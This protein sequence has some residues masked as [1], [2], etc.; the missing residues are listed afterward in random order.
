MSN[1]YQD[2]SNTK[3]K[4]VLLRDK[5]LRR[6]IEPEAE[7]RYHPIT[8]SLSRLRGDCNHSTLLNTLYDSVGCIES[9]LPISDLTTSCLDPAQ[10]DDILRGLCRLLVYGSETSVQTDVDEESNA[11]EDDLN[12]VNIAQSSD[13][14]T[15][16]EVNVL[17]SFFNWRKNIQLQLPLYPSSVECSTLDLARQI[18][19]GHDHHHTLWLSDLIIPLYKRW[20][21]EERFRLLQLQQPDPQ[22]QLDFDEKMLAAPNTTVANK[23]H[24]DLKG[25]SWMREFLGT[26]SRCLLEQIVQRSIGASDIIQGRSGTDDLVEMFGLLSMEAHSY[27]TLC[28][29]ATALLGYQWVELAQDVKRCFDGTARWTTTSIGVMSSASDTADIEAMGSIDSIGSLW[30]RA[31]VQGFAQHHALQL[32]R[33]WV[34]YFA[35]Y[36]YTLRG[37]DADQEGEAEANQLPTSLIGSDFM[38]AQKKSDTSSSSLVLTES[39]WLFLLC[40]VLHTGDFAQRMGRITKKRG[41]DSRDNITGRPADLSDAMMWAMQCFSRTLL[42]TFQDMASIQIDLYVQE[43][44]SLI[45]SSSFFSPSHNRLIIRDFF[46]CA[47]Q[48]TELQAAGHLQRVP[49][50]LHIWPSLLLVYA[51]L[52][53]IQ[54]PNEETVI[55]SLGTAGNSG[56]SAHDDG[57]HMLE[58]VLHYLKEVYRRF[59]ERALHESMNYFEK[60]TKDPSK[61]E[62]QAKTAC[63]RIG[64]K[65]PRSRSPA[66]ER[67]TQWTVPLTEYTPDTKLNRYLSRVFYSVYH[68]SCY[69]L[70][71]LERQK[72]LTSLLFELYSLLVV[73]SHHNHFSSQCGQL[74]TSS[75]F[76]AVDS[77]KWQTSD[78]DEETSGREA[79]EL[80]VA[81]GAAPQDETILLEQLKACPRSVACRLLACDARFTLMLSHA[82]LVLLERRGRVAEEVE[83]VLTGA[84]IPTLVTLSADSKIEAI[85]TYSKLCLTE[86]YSMNSLGDSTGGWSRPAQ[87]TFCLYAL[88]HSELL[89]ALPWS[90]E[91]VYLTLARYRDLTRYL[92]ERYLSHPKACIVQLEEWVREGGGAAVRQSATSIGDLCDSLDNVV[93]L[94]DPVLQQLKNRAFAVA[95]QRQHE[96]GVTTSSIVDECMRRV[97]PLFMPPPCGTLLV[98]AFS[99]RLM[100]QIYSLRNAYE[101][102]RRLVEGDDALEYLGRRCIFCTAE[103]I[104]VFKVVVRT[105][106][107]MIF[108]TRLQPM[109]LLQLWI[110]M[111]THLFTYV[112]P[113]AESDEGMELMPRSWQLRE[114]VLNCFAEEVPRTG[115]R[116]L[117][118]SSRGVMSS[119]TA[120]RVALGELLADLFLMPVSDATSSLDYLHAFPAPLYSPGRR[121]EELRS[122]MEVQ[123]ILPHDV[124]EVLCLFLKVNTDVSDGELTRLST[125]VAMEAAGGYTATP[126][127]A[128]VFD[129]SSF[130]SA[131]IKRLEENNFLGL[132]GL[133]AF[134]RQIERVV[135]AGTLK[136]T[137]LV[138]LLRC[139]WAMAD[140]S[141]LEW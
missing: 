136:D 121:K 141:A 34:R 38:Q 15:T 90:V 59:S 85:P 140:L 40:L 114:T 48:K 35:K 1:Q 119:Q 56:I 89:M 84:L 43:N 106:H 42:R 22:C 123:C 105:A 107:R 128:P 61:N 32:W 96:K 28:A 30:Q 21:S 98:L 54:V 118:P 124:L 99:R 12:R 31:A 6:L 46:W 70:L 78:D 81:L 14:L 74:P 108:A 37:T 135:V 11:H 13:N 49:S 50:R 131:G 29:G 69:P 132:A 27:R 111:L 72:H 101:M 83:S 7:I 117:R 80:E 137:R 91:G 33:R 16:E 62:N 25:S 17:P 67:Y 65:R 97:T 88:I 94:H 3:V 26:I 130:M 53:A 112:V 73:D 5:N 39:Q 63:I 86:V 51:Q 23:R 129:E 41:I 109:G 57:H 4:T 66:W 122:Q 20:Q 10:S 64:G 104:E 116:A 93:A 2:E 125:T 9:E 19:Q 44:L 77:S 133:V 113:M 138:H 79:T 47:I 134:C 127:G 24:I 76:F 18:V 103:D 92:L 126:P 45:D 87:A 68:S 8:D 100:Q 95:Q 71:L 58:D 120:L 139:I 102:Q 110:G 36:V 82:V 52:T 55:A 75:H 115:W 60:I